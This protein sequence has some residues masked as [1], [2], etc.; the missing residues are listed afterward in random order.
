MWE[1]GYD[2]AMPKL[3]KLEADQECRVSESAGLAD[4]CALVCDGKSQSLTLNIVHQRG[5]LRLTRSCEDS[6]QTQ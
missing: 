5:I 6:T 1:G 2:S 3:D 4:P